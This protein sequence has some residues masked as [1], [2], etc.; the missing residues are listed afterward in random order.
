[1]E[2][3]SVQ[4]IATHQL[5]G[6]IRPQHKGVF[7]KMSFASA[8]IFAALTSASL[9]SFATPSAFHFICRAESLRLNSQGNLTSDV[10]AEQVLPVLVDH[11]T[12]QP[13]MMD[14]PKEKTTAGKT[15][16]VVEQKPTT[17]EGLKFK[18][19]AVDAVLNA[20]ASASEELPGVIIGNL[21]VSVDIP[22]KGISLSTLPN[23]RNDYAQNTNVVDSLKYDLKMDGKSYII[24]CSLEP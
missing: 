11:D 3:V 1:V 10:L 2:N 23:T 19:G 15:A 6:L 9:S 21:T 4:Y 5:V 13:W 8:F 7:M 24:G 12:N 20:T 14:E 18:M 17:V 16:V 22:A